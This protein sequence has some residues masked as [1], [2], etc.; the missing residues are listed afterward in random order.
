MAELEVARSERINDVRPHVVSL[1]GVSGRQLE[2][3]STA[4]FGFL[5]VTLFPGMAVKPRLCLQSV[6]KRDIVTDSA[7][8]RL[9]RREGFASEE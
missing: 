4:P 5:E 1:T 7:T 8:Q 6:G 3:R 2:D 9:S